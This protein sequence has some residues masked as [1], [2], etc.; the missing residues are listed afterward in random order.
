MRHYSQHYASMEL[1]QTI[2]KK[3]MARQMLPN[4][5]ISELSQFIH[6]SG[7]STKTARIQARGSPISLHILPSLCYS[8][9]PQQQAKHMQKRKKAKV[10]CV[11][12]MCNHDLT[13]RPASKCMQAG[14]C[15]PFRPNYH[16]RSL[17]NLLS[18]ALLG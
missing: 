3:E 16:L 12:L 4:V 11:A 5:T 1:Q 2:Q 10:V 18:L 14:S 6:R 13:K 9:S 17:V 7:H 8:F 15:T